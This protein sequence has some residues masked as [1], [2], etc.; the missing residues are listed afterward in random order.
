MSGK[1]A[2]APRCVALVGPY[3]SGK[4][5]LFESLLHATGAIPRKGTAKEGNTVGD[6]SPE[7]RAHHMSVEISVGATEFLGDRWTII[8][9]P[10]SIEFVQ[11]AKNAVIVA[12][13]AVVVCEPAIE[14]ALTVAPILKFLDRH[15][16]PHMLFINRMDTA[17]S[18]VK[19]VLQAL[20][21]VSERPLVLRQ[22]PIRE[23]EHI[24]GYVDLVSERAYAY[25]PGEASGLVAIPDT[26]QEIEQEA[27][28]E[29]LES[30][31]DFDDSL[32]EQLLEDV[33]PDKDVIYGNLTKDL[34]EDLVVPVLLGAAEHD[35]G[36]RRLLKALRHEV[37]GP[38]ETLARMGVEGGDEPLVSV[39]KTYHAAHAGKLSLAR[40]WKGEVSDGMTLA[41]ERVSGLSRMMGLHQN[42]IAKAGP[43]EVVALGRMEGTA[44]GDVLTAARNQVVLP[45]PGT[46]APVFGGAISA[47]S[48][49]DEVKLPGA[50]AKLIEEDSSLSIE[51]NPDT[52]EFVL[53]G[54]GEIHLQIALERLR[55]K[56]N[57]AARMRPPQVPYK[58]TIR[59]STSQHGRFKRQTGGHG[60]FGDVHIDIKPL[61]RG[62]G[63]DFTDTIAGGAVPKQFIP[64]VGNGV[65]EYCSRGPLGFPVVD[66]AVTLTDGQFHAVDSSEQAFRQAARIAMTEGMPNCNPVLLEPVFEVK[67]SVPND[68]T[69]KVQRLISGRRGQILGFGSR[70]DWE[71]WDEV[72]AHIAQAEMRDLIID[73]RSLTL[74]V[75]TFDWQFDHLQE[76]TG[77]LADQVIASRAEEQKAS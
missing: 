64:A 75:G 33:I 20:Q 9:C 23:G 40:V 6:E 7:A 36:V 74:G 21:A 68:F 76:L 52:H 77:R 34:Q 17:A 47:E 48:R 1:P 54:Q 51:Q 45:S 46:T 16:I 15:K 41:G 39:F 43:G 71:G 67:I 22:V 69:A 50:V 31:A 44:T 8:D 18:P 27:R 63:F 12:D 11:D 10:G 14:R 42:K 2:T 56:Y 65:R 29:M 59:R 3:L 38:D 30:L 28:T 19:E 24:T 53:W 37:P 62:T 60:Q 26:V 25:R 61:P 13:A 58:E 57:I 66:I 4:T 70:E 73:L 72:S 49:S 55:S 5:T 35:H 32:L